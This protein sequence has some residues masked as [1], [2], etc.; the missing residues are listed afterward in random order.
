[1]L[2]VSLL[3]TIVIYIKLYPNSV[4][5]ANNGYANQLLKRNALT[6]IATRKVINQFSLGSVAKHL[7]CMIK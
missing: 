2:L 3:D 4:D 6:H 1:M 5:M 7:I